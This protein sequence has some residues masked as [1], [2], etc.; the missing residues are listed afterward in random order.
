[1][2]DAGRRPMGRL[3]YW[4]LVVVIAGPG[5]R[6]SAFGAGPDPQSGPATTTVADAVTVNV[7]SRN[8]VFSAIV[9]KVSIEVVDPAD[10]RGTYAIEFA[11]DL[12]APLGLQDESSAT[13]VA[14]QDLP[15]RLATTQV[16][17][18][19]LADLTDA[20]ITAVT[21]TTVSVD[22]GTAPGSGGGIEVRLHDFGWGSTNDRNLLG[23]FN[24]QTFSLARLARTQN[25]FLRLYDGSS[26]PKYSRYAAA[27]HVDYPL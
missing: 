21:S 2:F 26:P 24:T 25:Y 22:A 27:L 11:N 20:Q 8:A 13:T 23:R 7:P 12:A 19:Y 5:F 14:L 1:M 18:Y 10:D 6:L 17:S 16:G 9:R 3:F 4:L 15:V